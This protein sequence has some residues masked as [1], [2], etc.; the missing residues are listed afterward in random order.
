MPRKN[1]QLEGKRLNPNAGI[2]ED[3]QKPI[4]T[5]IR[6]MTDEVKRELKSMFNDPRYAVDAMDAD[7]A[8]R[9]RIILNQMLNKYGPLFQKYAKKSVDRMVK[10]T[11]RY[12]AITLKASLE[13]AT[14]A[15][16]EKTLKDLGIDLE[17]DSTSEEM[18][19][20]LTA[21]INEAVSLIKTIPEKYLAEVNGAVMRSVTS[22]NGLKDLI[23]FLNT[24]YG[25]NIRKAR[26][27]ANDQTRKVYANVNATRMKESGVKKFVWIHSGGGK[28]PRKLHQEMNGKE[29]SFDDPP[30]IGEMYG[31]PVYGLPSDLPNCRCTLKPILSFED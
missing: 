18:Q 5:L 6:K 26:N 10:R 28:H 11:L 3:F 14:T 24:K 22:G 17:F 9:G 13:G 21:S 4:L 25:Q 15:G 23:P 31:Q 19:R 12:S 8:A 2:I 20:V 1:K 27:V 30:Y 16:S 29:Y 7:P